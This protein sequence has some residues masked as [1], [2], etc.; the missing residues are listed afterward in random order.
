MILAW[1]GIMN[2]SESWGQDVWGDKIALGNDQV[3]LDCSSVVEDFLR[4]PQ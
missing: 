4:L 3:G 2:F 1:V